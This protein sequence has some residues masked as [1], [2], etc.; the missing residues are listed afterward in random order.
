MNKIF[1]VIY[2]RAKHCYVVASELAKSYSKGGGSRSIRRAAIALG[3]VAAVYAAA[4]IAIAANDGGDLD[5]YGNYIG[6][7]PYNVTIDSDVD[8]SVYGRKE[9]TVDSEKASVIVDYGTVNN[10]VY[11]GY[12]E[13]GSSASNSVNISGESTSITEFVYGGYVNT[14]TCDVTCNTVNITD[15]TINSIFGGT[16]EEGSGNSASN[17]VNISGGRVLSTVAGGT[18]YSG[19]AASNSVNISGGT[20]SSEGN[21]Y[22]G[23]VYE[24]NNSTISDNSL[25]LGSNVTGLDNTEVY[26]YYFESGSGTHSGNELHIGRAVDYDGEGNIQRDSEGNIKYKS[27]SS[28]IWHGKSSDG[29]VNNSINKIANFDTIALHSVARDNDLPAIKAAIENIGTVDVTDLKFYENGSEKTTFEFG[30]K[31]NLLTWENEKEALINLKFKLD[32]TGDEQTASFSDNPNGITIKTKSVSEADNGISFEG[33]NTGNINKV[34]KSLQ[35]SFASIILNSVDI[36]GWDGKN[37][38]E[39]PSGWGSNDNCV[40]VSGVFAK[41][42]LSTGESKII[43][44]ASTDMFKDEN[45]DEKIRYKNYS[46]FKDNS[47]NGISISGYLAGGVKASNGGK[48]LSYYAIKKNCR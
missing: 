4:G 36:S 23:Y 20:F 1:K 35:F 14:G 45:I 17:S 6:H 46:S 16:V 37:T 24:P 3:V 22:A 7:S 18:S 38:S 8:G 27:D 34:D 30:D 33:T 40:N 25:N 5:A 41:P 47:V 39:V 26:G 21:N 15:G 11:G 42:E 13:L 31:M 19:E 10:S 32:G 43:L 9:D 28:T 48:Y 29:T 12:S 2:N 44:T